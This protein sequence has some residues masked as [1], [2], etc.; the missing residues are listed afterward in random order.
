METTYITRSFVILTLHHIM[1][2]M[3][4]R[5]IRY[6]DYIARMRT[7]RNAY[8]ISVGKSEERKHS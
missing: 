5:R 1:M 4:L 6:K 2:V 8:S 7:T 3:R